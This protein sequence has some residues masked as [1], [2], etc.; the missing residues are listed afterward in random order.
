MTPKER[1]AA[2]FAGLSTDKIPIHHIGSLSAVAS[3]LLGREAYVGGGIQ[4][5]RE[6][7]ALWRGPDAHQEYL[8][9]SFQDAID[10]SMLLGNDIIR[11]SY[12]RFPRRPT[13]EIDE[14]TYLFENGPEERWQ[15]LRFDPASE[16]CSIFPYHPEAEPTFED[17]ESA[18]EHQ[19][20]ALSEHRPYVPEFELKA[21][22]FYGHEYAVRCPGCGIGIP[23]ERSSIWFEAIA[24][25][26]DLVARH[27]DLEVEYARRTVPVLAGHGFKYVFGGLDFASNEGPMYSPKAFH[28]LMLPRLKKI[29]AICHE[30]GCYFLFASDGN[31]WSVADD[32]FGASGVDGFYE[33]DKRAGMDLAEL[34]ERFPR[35]VT[36]GNISSHT[37][38]LGT[39][40]DVIREVTEA[41][42]AAKQYGRTVVG[43]SNAL[44]PGTPMENAITMVETIQSLR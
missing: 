9:R 39:K 42:D 8:E 38:H 33:I 28:E 36:I 32:L 16:Q 31:L 7:R 11:A 15:V 40:D 29:S 21:Q 41:I 22:Q 3:E 24:I 44:M 25:R 13:R 43:I 30:H 35:L 1:V 12:W 5:W 37:V 23:L 34:H 17:I 26:P 2:A 19:E 6:A 10:L 27:L 18:L 4:Q 20:E 14:N